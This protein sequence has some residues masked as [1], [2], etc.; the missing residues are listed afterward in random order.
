MPQSV[1]RASQA[2]TKAFGRET[3]GPYLYKMSV[4]QGARGEVFNGAI[5]MYNSCV[6]CYTNDGYQSANATSIRNSNNV[7]ELL[8]IM[9]PDLISDVTAVII[10]DEE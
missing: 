7:E 9:D 6:I 1:T 2:M 4:Y 10:E 3:D 8:Q 5:Y